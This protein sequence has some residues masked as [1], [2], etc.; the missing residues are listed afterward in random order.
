MYVVTIEATGR[1]TTILKFADQLEAES[2]ID[3][4]E[5]IKAKC[6]GP[7]FVVTLT[8]STVIKV[9]GN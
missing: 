6:H 9:I 2:L 5:R 1:E 3:F 4:I 7:A 8:H